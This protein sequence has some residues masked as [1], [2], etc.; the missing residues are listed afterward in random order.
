MRLSSGPTSSASSAAALSVAALALLAPHVLARPS[1]EPKS[2]WVR[3]GHGRKALS[4]VLKGKRS[5]QLSTL[6]PRADNSSSTSCAGAAAREVTAPKQNIWDQLDDIDA[7]GVV[8]WLFA[9][10]EFN[11]TVTENAT[12]W[13]NSV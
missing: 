4:N 5:A 10:P 6:A 7:A 8:A 2:A 12:A 13:D 1:P 11:L 9:Q 3:K